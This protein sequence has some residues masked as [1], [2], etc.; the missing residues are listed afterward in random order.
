MPAVDPGPSPGGSLWLKAGEVVYSCQPDRILAG[1]VVC[2]ELELEQDQTINLELC[3]QGWDETQSCPTGL[4]FDPST[5]AC[6]P[7]DGS[8]AC[9]PSCNP[10]YLA[11]PDVGACLID[12]SPPSVQEDPNSCPGGFVFNPTAAICVGSEYSLETNC[13]PGAYYSV[14]MNHCEL[15]ERGGVCPEGYSR[16]AGSDGCLPEA[17]R[18]LI[19]C[20]VIEVP[21]PIQEVTVKKAS[22]CVKGPD[23]PDELVSSLDPFDTAQILGLGE[24][25]ETLVINNPVYQIP[26]WAPLE[27]F[28]LDKINLD[29]LAI[30]R[31]D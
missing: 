20:Q 14:E 27:S 19:T 10:G 21:L 4:Y 7:D 2:Q 16:A 30:I 12:N 25:G 6:V 26:C 1:R 17:S 11:D 31:S 9:E 23:N 15:L 24:D 29:I 5:S 18:A 3:W 13:P 28:Y 22:R 8:T